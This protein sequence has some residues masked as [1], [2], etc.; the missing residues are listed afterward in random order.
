MRKIFVIC[1]AIVLL[2][3]GFAALYYLKIQNITLFLI[4]HPATSAIKI[5]NNNNKPIK[6]NLALNRQEFFSNNRS[7]ISYVKKQ[8]YENGANLWFKLWYFVSTNSYHFNPY[9]GANWQHTPA[10]YLNSLGFGYCDDVAAVLNQLERSAGYSAHVWFL[11]GHIAPEVFVNQRWLLLDPDFR[12]FFYNHEN[13]IASVQELVNDPELITKPVKKMQLN[14]SRIWP[15]F[16]YTDLK[17]KHAIFDYDAYGEQ[18]RNFYSH[19]IKL[20][21]INSWYNLSITNY[22]FIFTIPAHAYIE[23]PHIFDPKL[24]SIGGRDVPMFTNL[25]LQI[26]KNYQGVVTIPLILA[27]IQGKGRVEIANEIYTVPSIALNQLLMT[28]NGY[29]NSIKV[30]KSITP[31]K[32]IYLLN[33]IRFY[34][35]HFNAVKIYAN[36]V[37]I[38]NVSI[39]K[40]ANFN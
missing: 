9:T 30:I 10:L 2:T 36:N 19:N 35:K 40:V 11:S 7:I 34:L 28:R 20:H 1:S 21:S 6:F 27:T 38:D 29:I 5:Q 37:N 12:V 23:F 33:P 3:L 39:S 13:Q 4:P 25:L 32:F 22:N 26:P 17:N 15:S 14:F 24:L 16:I 31:L 18:Y 8:N